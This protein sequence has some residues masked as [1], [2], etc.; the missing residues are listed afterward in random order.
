[1][2]KSIA[3]L[4][5]L[6]FTFNFGATKKQKSNK[7]VTRVKYERPAP[8]PLRSYVARLLADENGNI[9]FQE[10]GNVVYPIASL[11]KMMTMLLAM[12]S[13]ERGEHSYQDIVEISWQTT[14]IRGI[15]SGLR[16]G[17]NYTLEDLMKVGIAHSSNDAAYAVAEYI[18]N[19]D[20]EGFI[21]KM[22]ARAEQL[23]LI[24]T[25]YYTPMG[26]PTKNTKK[27]LDV[28]SPIDMAKLG[29]EIIKH[30]KYLEF[31][32]Q[33][34]V[35]IKELKSGKETPFRNTDKM[36]GSYEGFDGLKTGFHNASMFNIVGTA[37]RN[38]MRF[39]AV[40]FGSDTQPLR[41]KEV[42]S[43]LDFAFTTFQT[44]KVSDV[45]KPIAKAEIGKYK[46]KVIVYAKENKFITEKKNENG[47][48]TRKLY[49]DKIENKEIKENEKIGYISI[50]RN[51]KEI[52]RVDAV[53]RRV[54]K[55]TSL[56]AKA[57]KIMTFGLF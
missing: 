43:L 53:A 10:N 37:K 25:K 14:T 32:S 1:M 49:L 27:P 6:M 15:S 7:S 12:E 54:E 22:N 31:S 35:V 2:K 52:A 57:V 45:S 26:L 41:A 48:L 4:F 13:I 20:V 47:K 16:R 11:T 36:V 34:N 39:I 38:N 23:G 28:S 40:V 5:I 46:Q 33:R 9:I 51:G 24:N 17:E 19:G 44:S 21:T 55:R 42:S 8:R 29:S 50:I 56:V 18:G 3:L 30:P